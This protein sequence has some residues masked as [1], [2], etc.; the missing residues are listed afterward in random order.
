[1]SSIFDFAYVQK[2][3]QLRAD[4]CEELLAIPL[5]I[6]V[7]AHHALAGIS[8]ICDLLTF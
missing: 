3:S 4:D 6:A 5:R 7:V 8:D 2:F 1:M